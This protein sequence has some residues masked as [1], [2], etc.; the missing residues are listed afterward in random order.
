MTRGP[1]RPTRFPSAPLSVSLRPVAGAGEARLD[2]VDEPA[3]AR[4]QSGLGELAH[5][6]GAREEVVEQRRGGAA[7]RR[8]RAH[9]HPRLGDEIGRSTRLNSSHA[10]ISYA[11]F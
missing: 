8:P 11:V 4:V 10:N 5:R 7:E 9:A 3:V 6:L 2:R 1:P